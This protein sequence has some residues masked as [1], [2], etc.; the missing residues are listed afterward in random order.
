MKV[1]D[2]RRVV[3]KWVKNDAL[4]LYERLLQPKYQADPQ[5][6]MI[7]VIDILRDF[8]RAGSEWSIVVMP[9]LRS[10]KELKLHS[11]GDL[12]D[13]LRQLLEVCFHSHSF[14]LFFVSMLN[15]R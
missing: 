8:P 15:V 1:D 5:N 10:C 4:Q 12:L 2:G 6:H 14:E 11:V 7:P 13:M 9:M 3:L